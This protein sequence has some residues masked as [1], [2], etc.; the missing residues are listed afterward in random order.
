MIVGT[1][2]NQ[3]N[4]KTALLTHLAKHY[5]SLGY[6]I[7]SNYWIQ[8]PGVET[9]YITT[10]S[11]LEKIHDGYVF[12]D[13]FWIW[14]DSR[15][16]GYS[17]VNAAVTGIL[18]NL[19]KRRCSL[20]YESKRMHFSD[21][22]IRELTDYVLEP[23]VYYNNN[24]SLEMIEQDML[25]P[26]DMSQYIDNLWVV[27]KKY[28]IVS[29]SRMQE[30]DD[31]NDI[32][33]KLSDVIHLYNTSEEISSLSKT[34]RTPGIEKGIKIE[35]ALEHYIKDI[36]PNV[37]IA[38]SK[39]SRGWDMVVAGYALACTSV[40][41]AGVNRF[42]RIDTRRKLIREQVEE[43][44]ARGW[45]PYWVWCLK[46]VW[47]CRKMQAI[48]TNVTM[49]PARGRPLSSVLCPKPP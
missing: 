12:L 43:A 35:D 8:I 20:F 4:G 48:D 44:N 10:I 32:V 28:R 11:D 42:P 29:E 40:R 49:L 25:Y 36:M 9:N 34:E 14:I 17:D 26:V 6:R 27:T 2:G 39:A 18:M 3:G 13:E 46:G 31:E 24:G 15:V 21:R 5:A 47:Q 22:R 30:V 41:S 19:R 33:F 23:H 45:K 7:Y 37:E 38:R 16:S 1:Q